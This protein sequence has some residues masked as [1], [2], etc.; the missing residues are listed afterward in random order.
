MKRVLLFV[1]VLPAAVVAAYFLL[2]VADYW[3]GTAH[4]MTVGYPSS[5]LAN[6]DRTYRVPWRTS[7]CLLTGTE[8]LTHTP[9]NIAV[10]LMV[11]LFGPIAAAVGFSGSVMEAVVQSA[12]GPDAPPPPPSPPQASPASPSAHTSDP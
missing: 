7:G 12:A 5:E 4:L 2:G 11:R 1:A 3:N 6:L 9:N 8:P 10:R